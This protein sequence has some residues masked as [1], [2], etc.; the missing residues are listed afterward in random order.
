MQELA[1]TWPIGSP[2]MRVLVMLPTY[3]EIENIQGV[4]ERA[5]AALPDADILVIDDGSPDGTAERAEKLGEV[6]VAGHRL[7]DLVPPG[8]LALARL[9][10]GGEEALHPIG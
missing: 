10:T 3:N 8:R 9:T 7:V 2:A 6:V 4:L 5:R 1:T